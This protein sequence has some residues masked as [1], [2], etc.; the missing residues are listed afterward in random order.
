M[1]HTPEPWK[2]SGTT[3]KPVEGKSIPIVEIPQYLRSEKAREIGDANLLRIM[4]CVNACAGISNAVLENKATKELLS[5]LAK[6]SSE[7]KLK[8]LTPL[9][10]KAQSA[11]AKPPSK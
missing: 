7:T 6:A 3:I 4:V 5:A 2:L 11:L 1:R 10:K 8:E 9:L